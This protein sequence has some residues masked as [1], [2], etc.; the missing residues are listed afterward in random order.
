MLMDAAYVILLA[1]CLSNRYMPVCS[2][3]FGFKVR[4]EVKGHGVQKFVKF[5]DFSTLYV[6]SA[7]GDQT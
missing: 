2:F 1:Q 3:S 7:K 6:L 5:L 4:A